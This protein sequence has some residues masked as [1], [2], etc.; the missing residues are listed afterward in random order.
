MHSKTTMLSCFWV[1]EPKGADFCP[2]FC[3]IQATHCNCR[4]PDGGVGGSRNLKFTHSEFHSSAML[5]VV[6]SLTPYSDYNQS[7]RNMYQC[8]MGK[9]TMGTPAQVCTS[10]CFHFLHQCDLP[11][12]VAMVRALNAAWLEHGLEIWNTEEILPNIECFSSASSSPTHASL[13]QHDVQQTL[14]CD[15]C[16]RHQQKVL[17]CT[18]IANAETS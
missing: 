16:C 10:A 5:S 14:T 6:A 4:C 7:P 1:L 11:Q 17:A 8:Q 2:L 9:Q 15:C 3:P 12:S 13:M 18:Y